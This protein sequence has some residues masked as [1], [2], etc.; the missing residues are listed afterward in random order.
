MISEWHSLEKGKNYYIETDTQ[1]GGGDDYFTLAVE[2]EKADTKA[3]HHT[4]KELVNLDLSVEDIKETTRITIENPDDGEFRVV[5]T[6]PT[7]FEKTV[8]GVMKSNCDANQ[9]R[10]ALYDFFARRSPNRSNISVKRT[11]IDA[12]GK[13]TL[14]KADAKKYVFDVK[15]T[16]LVNAMSMATS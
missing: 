15:L 8:S 13:E 11:F 10:N 9:M 4:M 1:E 14:V 2:I 3:H 5:F 6:H 7:S 16:K 12:A